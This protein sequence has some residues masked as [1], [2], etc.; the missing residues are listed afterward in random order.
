MSYSCD[1][2]AWSQPVNGSESL[3]AEAKDDVIR[4][5]NLDHHKSLHACAHVF[6]MKC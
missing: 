4:E 5:E 6:A 3:W 2:Q 1:S